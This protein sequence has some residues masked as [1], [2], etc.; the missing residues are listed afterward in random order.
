MAKDETVISDLGV[1]RVVTRGHIDTVRLAHN[2]FKAFWVVCKQGRPSDVKVNSKF[3][4]FDDAQ[5]DSVIL[6]Y[7]KWKREHMPNFKMPNHLGMTK[8]GKVHPWR[9]RVKKIEKQ[10]EM[11]D[12]DEQPGEQP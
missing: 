4:F 9:A 5:I 11:F 6:T 3:I 7:L 8:S 10:F 2:N 1:I 12:G